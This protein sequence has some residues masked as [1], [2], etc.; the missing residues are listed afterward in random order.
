MSTQ[1]FCLGTQQ[2]RWAPNYI[3]TPRLHIIQQVAHPNPLPVG[4]DRRIVRCRT[5]LSEYRIPSSAFLYSQ[6]GFAAVRQCSPPHSGRLYRPRRNDEHELGVTTGSL[7]SAKLAIPVHLSLS[8]TQTNP[9]SPT[10]TLR[11]RNNVLTDQ[12]KEFPTRT[13][14]TVDEIRM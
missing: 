6:R 13:A 7:E 9:T 8:A 12:R 10:T 1:P 4:L 14:F 5:L 3:I 11:E 2:H